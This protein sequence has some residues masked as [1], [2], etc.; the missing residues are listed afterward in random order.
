MYKSFT[1][2]NLDQIRQPQP[3]MELQLQWMDVEI[4]SCFLSITKSHM[5]DDELETE[6]TARKTS[7]ISDL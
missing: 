3:W 1:Y 2:I 4:P 7:V 6:V 5:F